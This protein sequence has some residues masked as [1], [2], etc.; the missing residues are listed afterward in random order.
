VRLVDRRVLAVVI[1]GG[2]ASTSCNKG[3]D[4]VAPKS[5]ISR[6]D[7][8]AL[9]AAKMAEL[10]K[11]DEGGCGVSARD[12]L[13]IARGFAIARANL[14]FEVPAI[15]RDPLTGLADG[16]VVSLIMARMDGTPVLFSCWVPKTVSSSS[17]ETALA[18]V[19][20]GRL[21]VILAELSVSRPLPAAIASL[22]REALEFQ[23]EMLS[24]SHGTVGSSSDCLGRTGPPPGSEGAS[25]GGALLNCC[26]TTT[27]TFDIGGNS[28][29][30]D[31]IFCYTD[32]GSCST[33]QCLIDNGYYEP[34][35]PDVA[36]SDGTNGTITELDSVTFV[37][38]VTSSI[39]A[40][41]L[42]W[43][44]YPASGTSDPWTHTCDA[45]GVNIEGGTEYPV[46]ITCQ[47]QVHGTGTIQFTAQ[48]AAGV[49]SCVFRSMPITGFGG[50]RSPIS[51][52]V[53]Q[54]FRS[55]SITHFGRWRSPELRS[56]GS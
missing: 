44:W 53:D 2:L 27:V 41:S 3:G 26:S 50:C 35:P 21:R 32:G 31:V 38:H 29:S 55:M 45:S 4:L 17:L 33:F 34:S 20:G 37:A 1:L 19:N 30:V 51:V 56:A 28:Y 9:N 48:N 47:V 54:S 15:K 46:L 23:F 11:F 12:T 18:K 22:S 49:G 6:I 43:H 36:I 8:R 16:Q 25:R 52:H 39:P 5:E 14:P 40:T 10:R 24:Q 13:G 7:G 42:G